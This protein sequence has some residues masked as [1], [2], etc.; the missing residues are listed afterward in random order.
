MYSWPDGEKKQTMDLGSTG[1]IPLEVILIN[2]INIPLFLIWSKDSR[3]PIDHN[4]GMDAIS[5]HNPS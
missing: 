1:L 3:E 4:V 2:I 5:S